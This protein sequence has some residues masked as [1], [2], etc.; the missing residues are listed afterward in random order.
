ML[1]QDHSQ[2]DTFLTEV[3]SHFDDQLFR[4]SHRLQ[5]YKK[6]FFSKFI[7]Q[8]LQRKW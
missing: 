5:K 4:Y 3:T 1:L 7:K 8:G 6:T 2:Q